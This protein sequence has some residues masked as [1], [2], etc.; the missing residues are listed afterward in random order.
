VKR[1]VMLLARETGISDFGSGFCGVA[2]MAY[3]RARPRW[4]F[5]DLLVL[6]RIVNYRLSINGFDERDRHA[7]ILKVIGVGCELTIQGST[8]RPL[9]L[10]WLT[11]ASSQPQIRGKILRAFLDFDKTRC[12]TLCELIEPHCC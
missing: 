12:Q 7:E 8:L 11:L 9:S 3:A 5:H 2:C 4:A 6:Q 1:E 10:S